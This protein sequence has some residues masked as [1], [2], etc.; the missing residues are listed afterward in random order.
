MN[1][2]QKKSYIAYCRQ[3]TGGNEMIKTYERT[4]FIKNLA[5]ANVKLYVYESSKYSGNIGKRK[6]VNYTGLKSWSIVDGDDATAIEAETDGSRIDE[7]HEYLVLN[8]IDGS[9]TTFRNSH[10]DMFIR[11]APFPDGKGK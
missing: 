8:F 3:K 1:F 4:M 5:D 7:N 9:T 6:E 2:L 10:V 11:K